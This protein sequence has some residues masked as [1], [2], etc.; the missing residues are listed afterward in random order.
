MVVHSSH[1]TEKSGSACLIPFFWLLEMFYLP[2]FY[3]PLYYLTIYREV[4]TKSAGNCTF[5]EEILNGK[6]HYLCNIFSIVV[7][8]RKETVSTPWKKNWVISISINQR[9]FPVIIFVCEYQQYTESAVRRFFKI[10]ALKNFARFTAKQ[11]VLESLFDKNAGLEAYK[12]I[13]NRLQHS[14]FPVNIAKF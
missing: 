8:R 6:L 1:L 10:R 14:Y 2:W 3:L 13:K 12:F 11:P 5:T 9:F 4:Q 7:T